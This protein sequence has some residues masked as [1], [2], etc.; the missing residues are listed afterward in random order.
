MALSRLSD[1]NPILMPI[2]EYLASNT[3]TLINNFN[4]QEAIWLLLALNEISKQDEV[5]VNI[6]LEAKVNG[7]TV[8]EEFIQTENIQDIHSSTMLTKE[9]K[10]N[11]QMNELS[12]SKSG[13]GDLFFSTSL[14]YSIE[15][16]SILP[17]EKNAVITRDY[18]ALE[19][20]YEE[21]P[22]D[23]LESGILYKGVL[24]LLIPEDGNYIVAT[25]PLPAGIKILSFNHNP[26][27]ISL[28]YKSE[29]SSRTNGLSWADNPLWLFDNYSIEEDKMMLYAEELPAGI[30]RIDYLVQAG[31]S[32]EYN[33]LPASI[34][35]L[36]KPDVYSR[37]AGGWM[38]VK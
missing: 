8:I 10:K 28:R 19:D 2:V 31:M 16:S 3:S 25:N 4:S 9:L 20:F 17:L 26:G 22:I 27:D 21:T 30:Y 12:I 37:T 11:G 1:E 24:N 38:K 14:S 13:S 29:E 6:N 5:N 18:Y 35:T 36:F 33:H 34:K 32:G 15:N 7:K 23:E